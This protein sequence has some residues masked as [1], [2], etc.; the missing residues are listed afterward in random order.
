MEKARRAG[1]QWRGHVTETGDTGDWDEA[2]VPV[3]PWG[4]R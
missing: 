2:A 4:V 1:E 3:G